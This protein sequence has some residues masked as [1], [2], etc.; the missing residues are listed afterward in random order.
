MGVLSVIR[1]TRLNGTE[2]YINAE[3]IQ[4]VESTPDSHITLLNGQ[5]YVAREPAEEIV[6]RVIAYQQRIREERATA[7]I[8]PLRRA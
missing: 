2:F 5:R 8:T 7:R 6:E 3:Q 4:S 1:L